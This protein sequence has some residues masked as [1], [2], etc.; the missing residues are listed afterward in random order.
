MMALLLSQRA[1]AVHEV[2]RILE[3]GKSEGTSDVVLVDHAPLGDNFVQRVEF[4][5]LERWYSAAAG[6]T[7]FVG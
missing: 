1:H 2:E 5:A 3:V 4:L 7:F 6:N